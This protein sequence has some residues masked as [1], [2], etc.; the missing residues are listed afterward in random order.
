MAV[1]RRSAFRVWNWVGAIFPWPLRSV[2]TMTDRFL[3]VIPRSFFV[4]MQFVGRAPV[5]LLSVPAFLH[6]RLLE[7][8]NLLVEF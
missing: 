4:L 8:S 6:S 3:A 1:H 2:S 7:A 5:V